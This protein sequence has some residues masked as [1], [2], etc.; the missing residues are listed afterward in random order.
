VKSLDMDQIKVFPGVETVTR[1]SSPYK[2]ASKA[3]KQDPTIITLKNGVQIGG[4]EFVVM[5]GPCSVESREQLEIIAKAV[6]ESGSRILRGGVFKPRT[7]PYAFQGL[8]I[9]GLKMMRE[10]ADELG[11]AIVTELMGTEHIDAFV[12]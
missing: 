11:M 2:L 5:S 4:D 7:S 1:I 9:E 12:E 6:K 3:F 8:G 10:V